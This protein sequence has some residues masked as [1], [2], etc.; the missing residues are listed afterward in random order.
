MK[1]LQVLLNPILKRSQ[2]N[3]YVVVV[4]DIF[5]DPNNCEMI[6]FNAQGIN[7]I[8]HEDVFK[9][10]PPKRV[11]NIHGFGVS[12]P[13]AGVCPIVTSAEPLPF[14]SNDFFDN[15]AEEMTKQKSQ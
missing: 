15:L 2:F 8:S 3:H 14:G 1:L 7:Y 6:T 11:Y 10:K 13:D 9:N 4:H 12:I 5:R